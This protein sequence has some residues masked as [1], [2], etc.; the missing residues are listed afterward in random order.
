MQRK[1]K[2]PSQPKIGQEN[3]ITTTRNKDNANI[4]CI[5]G[6]RK[7]VDMLSEEISHLFVGSIPV[8]RVIVFSALMLQWH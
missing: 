2:Q 4:Y 1:Q 8:D 6:G 7:Y 5:P 3:N